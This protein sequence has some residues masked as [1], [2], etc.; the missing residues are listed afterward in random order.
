LLDEAAG[1]QTISSP[2]R[3]AEL[4]NSL[5]HRLSHYPEH[6]VVLSFVTDLVRQAFDIYLEQFNPPDP[7]NISQYEMTRSI[8]RVQHFK[9]TL[10]AFPDGSPGEQVLV[11]A[12][13]VA[14]SGC[15][16]VEH[17]SF[18]EGVFLRHYARNGFGNIRR[19]L[20]YLRKIWARDPGKRWTS[21]MADA[22]F[23]VM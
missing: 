20:E 15:L 22:K 6:A 10:E 14:A 12:S 4:L 1:L 21:V 8:T 11:W 19:S 18:F 3:A 7:E 9:E 13:F 16:L 2:T 17:M 5:S 23:L